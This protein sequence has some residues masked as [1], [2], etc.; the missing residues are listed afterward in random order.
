MN[1]RLGRFFRLAVALATGAAGTALASEATP[2]L[3]PT[4]AVVRA[5]RDA[6]LVQAARGQIAAEEAQR[7]RLEAG[8]HEW[9]VRVGG[10]QRRT[11]PAGSP[12]ERY[13]EWNAAL[14]RPLRLPGKGAVD[15]RL[16]A[17]GVALAETGYGDALHEASRQLLQRWFDWLRETAGARQ[18][19]QQV[20]LLDQQAKAVRRRQALGDAARLE[21]VQADAALAQAE[22]QLAQARVRQQNAVEELRRRYPGLPLAEPE[23]I[24]EPA[25]VDG[26]ADDW[27]A[28]VLEHN[29]E[30]ALAR[31]EA[32]RAQL[33]AER[34]RRDRLPDPTVGLQFSRERSGEENVVGAYVSIPLPGDAR[35]ASSDA[36][37]AHAAVAGH[38]AEAVRQRVSV[39]AASLVNAAGAATASWQA[40][41]SAAERQTRS[42]DMLARAYQLGEGNLNDLLA[43]RRLAN[44]AQL[45]A[46]QQQLDALYLRYRLLLDTHRLWDID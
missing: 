46:R 4:E 36:S 26:L 7:Q 10:Q 14:E 39:E 23:S 45:A 35:R 3:P 21:S 34:S 6:P 30:W 28:A 18:W 43:A 5:L 38:Q 8:P 19:A 12:N 31:G 44:E 9:T 15:A 13:P 22:S 2:N 32:E 24:A 33:I 29:H 16:G 41:R 11:Q 25:P 37:A 1:S 40:A 17:Q 42:A 20:T 27:I